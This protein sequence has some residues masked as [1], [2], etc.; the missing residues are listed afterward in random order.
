MRANSIIDR[1]RALT[2]IAASVLFA[3]G[4]LAQTPPA[5][6]ETPQPDL[7]LRPGAVSRR[8]AP[9]PAGET[10]GLGYNGEAQPFLLRKK[11]GES[12]FLRLDN[13]LDEPTTLHCYGLHG[14]NAMDGTGSLTQAPVQPGTSFDYRFT[15]SHGGLYWL[16]PLVPG[17][18]ASQRARGLAGLLIVEENEPPPADRELVVV[19]TDWRVNQDGT[20]AEPYGGATDAARSGRLGNRLT[21]NGL[22]DAATLTLPPRSRVRLRLVNLANARIMPMRFLGS[23]A[24]VI[25]IDGQWVEPFD[26]LHKQVVMAPGSR[27]E[28]MIDLPAEPGR[29]AEV[30]IAL[31]TGLK[32]VRLLA[33]GT[34]VEAR[35]P[36]PQIPLNDLPAAIRLQHATRATLEITGGFDAPKPG[37]PPVAPSDIAKRFPDP[38]KIWTLNGGKVG[39]FDGPPLFRVKRGDPCVLALTN[40]TGWAQVIHTHGHHFRYLHPFDDGWEPYW[41][42]TLVVSPGQTIRVAFDAE[43]AGKWAIRSSIMEH[44][45]SGVATWLEVS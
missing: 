26:P 31:G 16:H 3:D 12:V 7:V 30:E 5:P 1:R 11:A 33:D 15:P 19:L 32:V 38:R 8:L 40:K 44:F 45:E 10:A 2:G 23:A 29:A 34:A 13:T 20:P 6:V 14:H 24:A 9:E 35:P 41:L 39:G 36:V 17:L 43:A 22:P 27:F 25:A 42:D 28:V 37:A 4:A 18:A 21:V